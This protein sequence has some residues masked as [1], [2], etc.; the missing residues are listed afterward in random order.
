MANLHEKYQSFSKEQ[1]EKVADVLISLSLHFTGAQYTES[2]LREGC[3]LGDKELAAIGFD[4][5][6]EWEDMDSCMEG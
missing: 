1:L 4:I 5:G 2:I 3:G 6:G